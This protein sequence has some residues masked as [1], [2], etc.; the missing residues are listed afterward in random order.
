MTRIF[1]RMFVFY[2]ENV[3]DKVMIKDKALVGSRRK[4][5]VIKDISRHLFREDKYLMLQSVVF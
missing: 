1:Y 5:S 3:C 4:M 2:L